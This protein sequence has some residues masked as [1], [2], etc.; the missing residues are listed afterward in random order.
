MGA[1][2]PGW[3][4]LGTL[5]GMVMLLQNLDDPSS[6]GPSMGIALVATFYGSLAANVIFNPAASKIENFHGSEMTLKELIRD[7]VLYIE[8]GERPDYIEADLM[9]YLPHHAKEL[10]EELKF[11]N[12]QKGGGGD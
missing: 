12:Q 7:G 9:N 5:T 2:G 3:G 4:M 10:Y 8:Q 11:E 1:L 6:I